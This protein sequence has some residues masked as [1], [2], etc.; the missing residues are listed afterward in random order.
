MLKWVMTLKEKV[1]LPV[2]DNSG[3]YANIAMATP[4]DRVLMKDLGKG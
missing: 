4:K 3:K 2:A 1:S